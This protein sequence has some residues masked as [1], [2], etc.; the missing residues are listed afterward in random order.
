[1]P[2]LP[3]IFTRLDSDNDTPLPLIVAKRWNFPLAHVRTDNGIFYA[4]QDWLRGLTGIDDVR[5][6][7]PKIRQRQPDLIKSFQTFPYKSTNDKIYQLPYTNEQGLINLLTYLRLA[8]G[9]SRLAAIRNFVAQQLPEYAHLNCPAVAEK[10]FTEYEFQAMLIK[11]LKSAVR[12][13]ELREY[14][15]TPSG[16]RADIAVGRTGYPPQLLIECKINNEEFYKAIGQ[17]I[18]YKTDLYLEMPS[19]SNIHLAIAMPYEQIDAYMR[20]IASANN[21]LLLSVVDGILIDATGTA[22]GLNYPVE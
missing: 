3:E 2:D 22:T 1:M 21:F 8:L 19:I 7:L 13:M 10:Q 16:R 20:K 18:C 11:A 17:L 5:R 9:R 6:I 15:P 4:I 14:Y 12:N